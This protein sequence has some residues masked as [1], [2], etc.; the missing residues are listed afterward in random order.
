MAKPG[1]ISDDEMSALENGGGGSS[2]SFISDEDMM[3]LEVTQKPQQPWSVGGSL[4]Q[5]LSGA[6][7]GNVGLLGLAADLNPFGLLAGRLPDLN[8]TE[9]KKLKGITDSFLPAEDP[10]YRYARTI[11]QFV[12][13]N[14][15][16]GLAGKGLSMA[17]KAGA[18]VDF[19]ASQLGPMAMT[20]SVFGGT[21]AQMAEDVTGDSVVAPLVGG[22]VGGSLPSVFSSLWGMGRSALRGATPAEIK[23]SA[24]LAQN[25]ATGLNALDIENAIKQR[26]SDAL[27]QFMSTAELTDNAGMGQLEKTLT[28]SGEAS[29]L[30]NSRGILRE[31]TRN[32]ILNDLSSTKAVN[33]EALGSS[34][35]SEAEKVSGKFDDL[36]R[37]YWGA[38]NTKADIPVTGLQQSLAE[39]LKLRQGGFPVGGKVENLVNQIMD[40]PTGSLSA[41][42]LKDIRSDALW[43]LRNKFKPGGDPV[44]PFEE[45]I[46]GSLVS[47]VDNTLEK[48]LVAGDYKA[49]QEARD[50]TRQSK[51]I[52]SRGTAGGTLIS[53]NARPA[54]ALQS[55]I[56]GDSQSIKELKLAIG[57]KPELLEDVKRGFLDSIPRDPQGN[58]TPS[59]MKNFLSANE[60]AVKELYGPAQYGAMDRVLKDLQSESNVLNNAMRSSKGGSVTAQRQTVAGVVHDLMLESVLPGAGP[61][62]RV[63]DSIKRSA[64]INDE[65]SV[66]ELLLRATLEPEFALEL[67]KTPTT[68]RIFN[69]VERLK[70]MAVDVGVS[71]ARSGAL[72]VG[73]TQE[74]PIASNKAAPESKTKEKRLNIPSIF[75]PKAI[76]EAESTGKPMTEQKIPAKL[77]AA[78]K[79]VE[80]AGKADAI[81]YKDGKPIAVGT[82]QVTPIAMR[83]VMR[84]QNVDDSD[85]SDAE[86]RK[87]ALEPG[88]SQEYGEAYMQMMLDRY[89]GD[90][91]LAAAAYNGGPSYIDKMLK[92][93]GGKTF[94]DIKDHLYKETR[95]YV[96]KITKLLKA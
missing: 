52:F 6:V 11:G 57:N 83:E 64:N 78:I 39:T 3:R 14:A 33:P 17:G 41:G 48:G 82:H 21:G 75:T 59:R 12:G 54:K 31:Q 4:G 85:F 80:S 62:G 26:P 73:R 44:V 63:V 69:V 58:L 34:L 10:K 55:V 40:A 7:E 74:M 93:T 19:L 77:S 15:G 42:A 27:G 95:D 37:E 1:F 86:L 87:M 29:N 88:V 38:V 45:K 8:F 60:G 81:S 66:K 30:Y 96:P 9:S 56:K 91:E 92:K 51:S 36:A 65:K 2:P 22:V 46:L 84:A 79:Q 71:A 49:L 68:T 23:G 90:V 13:P 72:E 47:E 50:I 24:A 5:L 35:I 67:S 53:D 28:A 16:L 94:E 18:G 70:K 25:E 32:A 89:N 43:M 61:L 76:S 20:S